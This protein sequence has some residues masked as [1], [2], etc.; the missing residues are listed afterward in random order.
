MLAESRPSKV[1]VSPQLRTLSLR[2]ST[3]QNFPPGAPDNFSGTQ[4]SFCPGG[5]VGPGFCRVS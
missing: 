3:D 4:D 2:D 5:P 1:W